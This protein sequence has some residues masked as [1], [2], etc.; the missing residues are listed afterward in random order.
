MAASGSNA[1][2]QTRWRGGPL[3]ALSRSP[4]RRSAASGFAPLRTLVRLDL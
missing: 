1:E 3:A 2:A 4:S